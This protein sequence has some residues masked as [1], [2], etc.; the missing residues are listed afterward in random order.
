MSLAE[1]PTPTVRAVPH[2]AAGYA[3]TARYGLAV[4]V[5]ECMRNRILWC[6]IGVV[7]TDRWA[8]GVRTH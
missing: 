4:A 7:H 5:W 8:V 3:Q 6:L 1:V 2:C